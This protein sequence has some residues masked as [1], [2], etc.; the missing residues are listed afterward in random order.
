MYACMHVWWYV[1]ACLC[2][3]D[4]MYV[5]VYDGMYVCDGS[6]KIPYEIGYGVTQVPMYICMHAC[7]VV[8]KNVFV[9]S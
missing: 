6:T 7:M 3:H 2:V 8:C 9:C 1:N 4:G 5:C